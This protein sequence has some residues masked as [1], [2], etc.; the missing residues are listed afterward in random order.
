MAPLHPSVLARRLEQAHEKAEDMNDG[1][2]DRIHDFNER[3]RDVHDEIHQE[4]QDVGKKVWEIGKC[5]HE[6]IH[7]RLFGFNDGCI[8]PPS[9]FPVGTK[10]R[11]MR[12]AALDKAPLKGDLKTIVVLVDFPNRKF[13][14]NHTLPFFQ[15]TSSSVIR[16]KLRC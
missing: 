8:Y 15:V 10:P 16:S 4:I 11:V 12:A 7:N 2:L 5:V 13:S 9:S 6:R 14:P 3:L 1:V